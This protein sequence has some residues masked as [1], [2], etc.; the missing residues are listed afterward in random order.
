MGGADPA[1]ASVD[2][3]QLARRAVAG[4]GR[5]FAEI[6]ERHK[7]SVLGA[8]R[9]YVGDPEAQDLAQETFVRAF[10][11][12]ERFDPERPLKPWLLAIARNLCLDRLRAL[13]RRQ[14]SEPDMSTY[15]HP[16]DDAEA[17]VASRQ[18]LELLE[19]GLAQ[20]PE[21]QREAVVMFHLEGMTYL[22]MSDVLGVP[23]G[24]VMTW[25]H[26]GRKRLRELV[27][28]AD[29]EATGATRV[30]SGGG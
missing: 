1:R 26:R 14:L 15:P 20:L 2:E 23:I 13:D 16:A 4:D 3:R 9:R 12:R 10:V 21:G 30:S 24:T 8:C 18:Q 6:V 17:A 19:R 22:E 28:L 29:E 25:L 11:H 5:A 27:R 7:G